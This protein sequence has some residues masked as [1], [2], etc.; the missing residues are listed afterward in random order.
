[1]DSPVVRHD[2]VGHLLNAEKALLALTRSNLLVIFDGHPVGNEVADHRLE[3]LE[4]ECVARLDLA[5]LK[6]L[7]LTV[8]SENPVIPGKRLACYH[9]LRFDHNREFVIADRAAHIEEKLPPLK[10]PHGDCND[11]A[12]GRFF[13]AC[14]HPE[15]KRL[16][17]IEG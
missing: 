4:A 13:A 15:R 16:A 6:D 1:M 10:L 17:A 7:F 5:L 3:R 11:L 9:L 12:V 2:L 14:F 8:E